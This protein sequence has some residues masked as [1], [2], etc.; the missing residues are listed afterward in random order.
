MFGPPDATTKPE[1]CLSD[2]DLC[3]CGTTGPVLLGLNFTVAHVF[4][5]RPLPI[6]SFTR[7]LC[8]IQD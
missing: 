5:F 2:G 1:A 7:A 4:N 3:P 8:S 6:C